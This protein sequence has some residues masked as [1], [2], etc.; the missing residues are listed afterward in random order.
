M[1]V[2]VGTRGRRVRRADGRTRANGCAQVQ[3]VLHVARG[4]LRR[5]VER[6][7]VVVVVLGLGAVEDLVALARED[8]LDALAQLRQR[9]AVADDGRTARAA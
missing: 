8:G 5:H 9:M 3:R 7:E 2:R 4:V 6:F 1:R